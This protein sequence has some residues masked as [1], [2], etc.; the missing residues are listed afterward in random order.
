MGGV[1]LKLLKSRYMIFERSPMQQFLS[2]TSN[3]VGRKSF[4]DLWQR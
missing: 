1:G 2:K 4:D 3:G